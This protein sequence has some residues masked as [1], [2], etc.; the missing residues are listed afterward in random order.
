MPDDTEKEI[1]VEPE[2]D[3]AW[4]TPDAWAEEDENADS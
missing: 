4:L 1:A 2:F 3:P